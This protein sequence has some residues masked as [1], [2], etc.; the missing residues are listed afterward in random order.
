MRLSKLRQSNSATHKEV[1]LVRSSPN[2]MASKRPHGELLNGDSGSSLNEYPD[3]RPRRTETF[4][5]RQFR[6]FY[7]RSWG[8]KWESRAVQVT[9]PPPPVQH[10]NNRDDEIEEE[11]R[12]QVQ[13]LDFDRSCPAPIKLQLHRSCLLLREDFVE[14]H[15]TIIQMGN[16]AKDVNSVPILVVTG[17]P[18]IGK[19]VSLLYLLVRLLEAEQPV[20]YQG[21]NETIYHYFDHNGYQTLDSILDV[22]VLTMKED[23][24]QL[25]YLLVDAGRDKF[26][27]HPLLNTVQCFAVTPNHVNWREALNDFPKGFKLWYMKPWSWQELLQIYP[28]PDIRA[29]TPS[30]F[31]YDGYIRFGGS[32]R[33]CLGTEV[34]FKSASATLAAHVKSFSQNDIFKAAY[35]NMG[36][37]VTLPSFQYWPESTAV[38]V[39][40]PTVSRQEVQV[41]FI[42]AYVMRELLHDKAIGVWQRVKVNYETFN[43]FNEFAVTAGI[44]FEG[45]VHECLTRRN[46]VFT[47]RRLGMGNSVTLELVWT[48]PTFI[49][50]RSDTPLAVSLNSFNT[51]VTG[52][53]DRLVLREGG[54]YRSSSTRFPSFNS[55]IIFANHLYIFQIMTNTKHTFN[56]DCLDQLD[57]TLVLEKSIRIV[58]IIPKRKEKTMINPSK[59]VSRSGKT[60]HGRMDIAV[61]LEQYV[62]ELDQEVFLEEPKRQRSPSNSFILTAIYFH[63]SIRKGLP[64]LRT[65]K[66]NGGPEAE[67]RGFKHK[68][69]ARPTR[70]PAKAGLPINL[71]PNVVQHAVQGKSWM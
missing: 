45:L 17:Q 58:F 6:L 39:P 3:K 70:R 47:L 14:L 2:A 37:T 61:S 15:E 59:I 9:V 25:R 43:R 24:P 53:P 7:D 28:D 42:S 31:L 13:F 33:I 55:C 35:D 48:H 51:N 68:M 19:S 10:P 29:A 30:D 11:W 63:V 56:A 69:D 71:P 40:W 12:G 21:Y 36:Q 57:P 32:A 1:G 60:K 5:A 23:S 50:E 18:G 38:L 62:L 65:K 34:L 66:G 64:I 52:T 46:R 44:M 8:K 16:N 41:H 67:N 54:Y 26:K 22:D 4:A 20:S 49:F 27:I